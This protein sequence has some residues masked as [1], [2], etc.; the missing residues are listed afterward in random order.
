MNK[1]EE[2]GEEEREK[3]WLGGCGLKFYYPVGFRWKRKTWLMVGNNSEQISVFAV[4][5]QK[6]PMT[7]AA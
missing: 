2:V 4:R 5:M 3:F 6:L 1:Y 7:K